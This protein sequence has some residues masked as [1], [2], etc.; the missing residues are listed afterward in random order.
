MVKS[1]D[2]ANHLNIDHLN[3][4]TSVFGPVFECGITCQ[5]DTFNHLKTG[6]F[7]DSNANC[8]PKSLKLKN[9]ATQ[10]CSVLALNV[11][12]FL[13][14]HLES[15][16][17]KKMFILLFSLHLSV[18]LLLNIFYLWISKLIIMQFCTPFLNSLTRFVNTDTKFFACITTDRT[19]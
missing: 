7:R 11:V 12:S 4:K 3:S 18:S 17:K 10:N 2:L 5:L 14:I 13:S 16:Y 8:I 9:I 1:C 15:S 19:T 6:L